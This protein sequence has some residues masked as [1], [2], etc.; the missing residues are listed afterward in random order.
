MSYDILTQLDLQNG[1]DAT[2]PPLSEVSQLTLS[3]YTCNA[4]ATGDGHIRPF[5]GLTSMG[6]GTGSRK[7]LTVGATWG[8]IKDDGANPASGSFFEDIGRSLWGI[9]S[10][11]P[12]IEGQDMPSWRLDSRLRVALRKQGVV[13]PPIE[14]GL[15]QPSAP[16]VGI[17]NVPGGM[18]GPISVKIERVRPETGARSLASPS[19]AVIVPQNNRVRV[20]F[21]L[22]PA[23]GHWRV[24]FTFQG[25]GGTGIHYLSLYNGSSDISETDVA[26]GTVDGIARSLEFDVKD[27][28]L[29][30]IE[31]SY[32]DYPPPAGTHALRLENV[33][34][35]I[36]CYADSEAPVTAFGPGTSIAVSKPNA[37]ESYVPTHLLYLPEPVVDVLSR[38][39]DDYGYVACENSIHAIQYIGYRGEE[40]S[41]CA[42]TTILPDIGIK[43]QHNWCHFRGRLLMYTAQGSLLLMDEQGNF[44]TQF[45]APIARILAT[46]D[47]EDTV[48]GY[49][50]GN[51]SVIVGCGHRILVY[52]LS[53]QQWRQ[54]YLPDFGYQATLFATATA[55]RRLYLSL[56]SV[57]GTEA[58]VWDS[59]P[60]TVAPVA[61]VTNYINQPGGNAAVKDINELA[62]SL[63]SGLVGFDGAKFC[64]AIAKNRLQIAHREIEIRAGER[65]TIR[66]APGEF[67]PHMTGKTF[68]L[69]GDGVNIDNSGFMPQ[70]M[71]FLHG[72]IGK[73]K[74]RHEV[75]VQNLDG[76]DWD[77]PA[78]MKHLLMFVGDWTA[79]RDLTSQFLA[80]F[81][82][83]VAEARAYRIAVWFQGIETGNVLTCDL[84]GN[85]YASS[86]AK[87]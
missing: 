23:D 68:F 83:Y 66:S 20:T 63:D 29:V 78:N 12:H 24:Y 7:M 50:P 36:G 48:V 5:R 54:I 61:L 72:R 39:L 41:A 73:Y 13:Q 76:T 25:F 85:A 43:A 81:F 70:S 11:I 45:A 38:P 55:K 58:Y 51:D 28:D 32:D 4:I 35:I 65:N 52:S 56:A 30:P 74:S 10:G 64:I 26:A 8:G 22:G 9:G 33:M 80:N 6:A 40:Y 82:P 2:A 16:E 47:P 62:V 75:Y 59:D 87:P 19:S 27:G 53:R 42:I 69:F 79:E 14:A 3:E 67:A 60:L 37:Y 71:P 49:D 31:A 46:F 86:R 34:M 84:F 17:V 18:S 57:A 21:P 77:P 44:D 1:I 15:P